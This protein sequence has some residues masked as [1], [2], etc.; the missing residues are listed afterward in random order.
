M[1]AWVSLP[2]TLK[3]S[4]LRCWLWYWHARVCSV[5][6]KGIR[7]GLEPDLPQSSRFMNKAAAAGGN[8][9]T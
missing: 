7:A 4:D 6:D 1:H 8:A 5:F 9:R 3:S 2:R